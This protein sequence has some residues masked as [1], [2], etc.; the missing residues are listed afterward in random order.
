M[1]KPKPILKREIYVE[2][3]DVEII[4]IDPLP[5]NTIAPPV[6]MGEKGKVKNITVD[7]AGNQHLDLGIASKYE[8]ITSYETG[9][10]LVGGDVIH[11]VHPSRVKKISK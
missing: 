3:D 9:E 6:K 7:T 1:L 8:Y 2:G 10:R 11:W 5:D 4:N